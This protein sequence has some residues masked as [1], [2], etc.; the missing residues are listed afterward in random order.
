MA[1][2]A[3]DSKSTSAV[4]LLCPNCQKRLPMSGSLSMRGTAGIYCRNC[5]CTVQLSMDVI[6]ADQKQEDAQ[7]Q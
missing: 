3:S 2:A 6:A 5:R 7:E 4:L 1:A